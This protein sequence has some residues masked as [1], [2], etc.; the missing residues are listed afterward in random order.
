M[1]TK[2]TRVVV[3]GDVALFIPRQ[4]R[5]HIGQELREHGRDDDAA[6]ATRRL[7]PRARQKALGLTG[8]VRYAGWPEAA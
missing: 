4:Q 8:P 1:S 7:T 2:R 3:Q 5:A 6:I